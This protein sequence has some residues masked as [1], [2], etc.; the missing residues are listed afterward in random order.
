[1]DRTGI[2]NKSPLIYTLASVRFA[3]WPLLSQKIAEIHDSLR[4]ITPIIHEVQIK[5]FGPDNQESV[6]SAW[7]LLSKDRTLGIYLLS[8]QLLV[9]SSKYS[10]YSK[11]SET[12]D[13]ALGALFFHMRFI[14]VTNMGMRYIDR[15]NIQESESFQDYISEKLLPAK[16]AGLQ[17]RGGTS[18]VNFEQGDTELRVRCIT[19]P[20]DLAFPIDI[21]ELLSMAQGPQKPLT[22]EKLN[23]KSLLLDIDALKTFSEPEHIKDK[24]NILR[25]LLALHEKANIFF[26]HE[27]VC[28]DHAFNIWKGKV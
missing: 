19:N 23:G 27:N 1:M 26:R 8:E 2:L 16:L 9:F 15:I 20:E 28:T 24:G 4:E 18:L 22:F 25:Q 13:K 3:P 14:D 5:Q 6:I 7:M 11:F 12:L 21:I 10:R 17:V